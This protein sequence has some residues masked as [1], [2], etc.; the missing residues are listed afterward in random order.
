[1]CIAVVPLALII[2]TVVS[3]THE[4]VY[5]FVYMHYIYICNFLSASLN[6]LN[7]L[8]MRRNNMCETWYKFSISDGCHY[9]LLLGLFFFYS[10]STQTAKVSF[11]TDLLHVMFSKL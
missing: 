3:R 9:L 4:N 2:Y 11:M 5:I 1:M 8:S 7:S 6:S 10:F